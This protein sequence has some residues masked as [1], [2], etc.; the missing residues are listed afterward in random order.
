MARD[1]ASI[2]IDIWSDDDW[3]DLDDGAQFLYLQLL[4]HATMSYA[5][6]V[7][8]RPKRIAALSSNGSPSEVEARA[9]RLQD[10]GF[11]L[12][13][14]ETEEILVRSFIKHDGLLKHPRLPVSL[15]LAF[16]GIGSR[17][18]RKVVAFELRKHFEREP[19]LAAWKHPQVQ[20]ILNA[21]AM[22]IEQVIAESCYGNPITDECSTTTATYTATRASSSSP[23]ARVSESDFE[24]A[25][26]H[27]PKKVERKKSFEKF[28]AAAK[29]RGLEQLIADVIRFGDAYARTTERQYTPALCVWLGRE[30]WTD[31]LPSA[32]ADTINAQWDAALADHKPDPC[33]NGHRWADDNT[34]VRYP[35]AALRNDNDETW[36]QS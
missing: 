31:D 33:A 14:D 32:S 1:R 36:R 20:S 26:T 6:V 24:S 25:W 10:Q 23:A 4:S 30:R 28:K 7:D 21:E 5:G 29:T 27:W 8:W 22:P 18:I 3:C 2:K 17:K 12:I 9:V 16:A 11:V 13:D 34:C 19:D 15:A 35:C